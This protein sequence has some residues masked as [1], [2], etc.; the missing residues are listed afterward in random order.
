MV[1]S[2]ILESYHHLQKQIPEFQVLYSIIESYTLIPKIR[3][4]LAFV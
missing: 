2:I 4:T 1:K 3:S